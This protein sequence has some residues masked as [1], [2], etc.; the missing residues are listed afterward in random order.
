MRINLGDEFTP[1]LK[2]KIQWI[3][4]TFEKDQYRIVDIGFLYNDYAVEFKDEKYATL[5]EL[6]W[7]AQ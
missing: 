2:E 1:N 3:K 6:R 5:F 4:T 7:P